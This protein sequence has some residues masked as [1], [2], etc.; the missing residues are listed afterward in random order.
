MPAPAPKRVRSAAPTKASARLRRHFRLEAQSNGEIIACFDGYSVGLGTFSAAAADRAKELRAGLPLS[1]I[2]SVSR[3]IDKEM[4]LL[5]RRLARHGLLEYRLPGSQNDED[6]VVIEPQLADYWPQAPK[7]GEADIIVLS[8]FA[9]MRRRGSELVLESP[10]ASALFR[11][12]DPT[13][14]AAI[15]LLAT[16]QPIKRLRRQKDFPGL[17]L[18]ALLVD[19][20]ILFKIDAG[21][22]GL[23]PEEGDEIGRAHV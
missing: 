6:Q 10:R 18:L 21:G 7:L 11:I 12:C 1:S 5:V 23:R 3:N 2:S 8:R 4:G 13:I 20:Q 19:C 14:A 9:Y 16:P 22:A 15:A 17:E